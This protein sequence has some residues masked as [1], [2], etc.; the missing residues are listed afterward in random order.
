MVP[1]SETGSSSA[2]SPWDLNSCPGTCRNGAEEKL[3]DSNVDLEEEED[4]KTIT[5]AEMDYL[6]ERLA[7]YGL[8]I[9]SY[10]FGNVRSHCCVD[11]FL[12]VLGE[13]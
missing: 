11:F 13:S 1:S 3:P 2:V 4:R 6:K 9:V 12:E 8:G 5:I 7:G 10:K